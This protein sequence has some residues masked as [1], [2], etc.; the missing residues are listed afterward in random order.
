MPQDSASLRLV[1]LSVGYGSKRVIG[2]VDAEFEAGNHFIVGA[3]GSGKSSFL[4]TLA[5]ILPVQGGSLNYQGHK[6][7][8]PQS[9]EE[10]LVTSS[11]LPQDSGQR[12]RVTTRDYLSYASWIY[13]LD[14]DQAVRRVSAL[15]AESGLDPVAETALTKLSG[16][17]HRRV[18]LAAELVKR[19]S[20]L[21]LDE[22]SSGLDAEARDL[23]SDMLAAHP[24]KITI[25]ASHEF[26]WIAE[27]GGSIWAI[28]EGLLVSPVVASPGE[29]TSQEV[30]TICFPR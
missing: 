26:D 25:T 22:P 12:A 29:L 28:R 30:R 7:S 24:P 9:W 1:G 20:L 16:G 8:S 3:N 18:R 13:G 14:A 15:L 5:G 11:Y 27:S 4:S 19:P 17:M 10:F 2:P 21:L 23:M 6:I